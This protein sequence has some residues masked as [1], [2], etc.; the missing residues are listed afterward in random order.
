MI[1]FV[2]FCLSVKTFAFNLYGIIYHV[3]RY[4]L[5]PV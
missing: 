1:L 4:V 5:L 2:F 3:S